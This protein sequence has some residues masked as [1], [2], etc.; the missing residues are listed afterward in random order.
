MR[1]VVLSLVFAS[2]ALPAA[3]QVAHTCWADQVLDP[4]TG[5]IE[6]VTRCRVAGEIVDYATEYDVPLRLYPAVGSADNGTCWY[7]RSVW[8]GWEIIT[9]ASDGSAFLG[10][11]SD[12]VPG[13]PVFLDVTY[14]VCISEPTEAVSGDAL[15]WDLI[16]DY[17]HQ[18]PGP[19]LNPAVPWGLTGAETHVALAPPPPFADSIVDPTGA[20]LDVTGM[21]AAITIDWGDGAS[22]TFAP[23]TFPHLTGFPDGAARHTYEVK[24]CDLPGSTP[25]CH[26]SLSSYPL[27]VRFQWFVQWRVG[28]G[29]WTTLAVPD[30]V[31]TV[32]YPVLEIISV[33]DD[34]G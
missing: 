9:R 25:R 12:G 10:F 15:A 31:T 24:T 33:L 14:P 11:D 32:P 13:G 5:R 16:R 26:P 21:V 27:Q 19:N 17:V 20:V 18:Q 6:T 34:R 29:D 30:T 7:W 28:G 1:R 3:A 22:L 2:L 4:L 23:E 8:S